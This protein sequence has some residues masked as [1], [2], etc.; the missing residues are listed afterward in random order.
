MEATLRGMR[1]N[2]RTPSLADVPG[3]I[4]FE[5]IAPSFRGVRQE[6]EGERTCDQDSPTEVN[7][8]S[9]AQDVN[10]FELGRNPASLMLSS[11][12]RER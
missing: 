11:S 4:S 3:P 8:V 2:A 10:N 1:V 9:N 6:S 12:S 5:V 7:G